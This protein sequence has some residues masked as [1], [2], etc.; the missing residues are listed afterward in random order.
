MFFVHGYLNDDLRSIAHPNEKIFYKIS[1]A[2][3][4]NFCAL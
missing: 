1:K 3:H 2:S 4:G